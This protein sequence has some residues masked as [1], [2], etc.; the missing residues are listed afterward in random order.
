VANEDG[1]FYT[2]ELLNQMNYY[3]DMDVI[4]YLGHVF[5][6]QKSLD[7]IIYE[8]SDV[9]DTVVAVVTSLDNNLIS[10]EQKRV[11][12]DESKELSDKN[13]ALALKDFDSK[14]MEINL[15]KSLEYEICAGDARIYYNAQSKILEQIEFYYEILEQK[16]TYFSSNRLDIIENYPEILYSL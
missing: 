11:D 1:I 14:S 12:C 3:A 10:L 16:Y 13:F 15:N 8:I 7:N 4:E 9:L 5:D 6:V 2:V